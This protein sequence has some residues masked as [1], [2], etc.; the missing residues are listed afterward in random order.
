MTQP[1]TPGRPPTLDQLRAAARAVLAEHR[2][3]LRDGSPYRLT[4]DGP[5]PL[6]RADVIASVGLLRQVGLR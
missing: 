4:Q 2:V 3:G 6:L 1:P 5:D